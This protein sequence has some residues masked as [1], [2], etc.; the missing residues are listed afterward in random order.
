MLTD[1]P[2]KGFVN[3]PLNM[4]DLNC[5]TCTVTQCGLAGLVFGGLYPVSLAVPVKGGLEAQ[6]PGI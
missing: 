1:I 3:L 5:E 4:G 2:H 6:R